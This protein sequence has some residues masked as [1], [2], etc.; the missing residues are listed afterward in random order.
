MSTIEEARE[1]ARE[2]LAD[3][4]RVNAGGYGAGNHTYLARALRALLDATEPQE[5]TA[6]AAKS[7]LEAVTNAIEKVLDGQGALHCT[8]VWE[9]WGYGTMSEEDFSPVADDAEAVHEIASA[10]LEALDATEPPVPSEPSGYQAILIQK[11]RAL[12]D[13]YRR[14]DDTDELVGTLVESANML[15]VVEAAGYS[16]GPRPITDEMVESAAREYHER[17]NGEGSYARASE[18]VRTSLLFRMKCA[19]NAAEEARR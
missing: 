12:A 8:R 1:Q 4:Q 6:P 10:V 14:Y 2:T 3:Y 16:K 11:A 18:H 17:G 15:R 19:L 13:E 7:Q 9:A 5:T